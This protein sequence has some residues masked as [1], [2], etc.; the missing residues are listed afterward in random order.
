MQRGKVNVM[1][2]HS[3]SYM[4]NSVLCIADEMDI[5]KT[6]GMEKSHQFVMKLIKLGNCYDCN[7]G[8]ILEKI[9][10]NLGICYCCL[11]KTD[12]LDDGLC[13]KCR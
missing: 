2:N 8:E 9:G 10:E 3:G 4:L 7:N 5:L 13:K 1:S 12:D 6:I 11:A